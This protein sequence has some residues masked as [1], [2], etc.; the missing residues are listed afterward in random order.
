MNRSGIARL[1][2]ATAIALAGALGSVNPS[3]AADSPD[4]VDVY[5]AGIAC[6]FKLQ[7]EIYG[8]SKDPKEFTSKDGALKRVL[9]NG[10]GPD[11]RYVNAETGK[12]L[13]LKGN[14][15]VIDLR[16]NSDGS[17]TGSGKGHTVLIL[18]PTDVP[19][20][21]STTL[22]VGQVVFTIATDGVY[23]VQK[24]SGQKTDICAALSS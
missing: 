2:C 10:K 12:A 1:I 22:Y 23:T 15:S 5:D 13:F 19:A 4:R 16:F 9:F 18:Y 6:R 24:E 8:M 11:S 14:G 20:G 3:M 7:V 17:I 21:P